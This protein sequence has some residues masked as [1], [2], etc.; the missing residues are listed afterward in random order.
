MKV[1]LDFHSSACVAS[2]IVWISGV[3][4]ACGCHFEPRP[5][6]LQFGGT[7]T[8]SIR[9]FPIHRKDEHPFS[10]LHIDIRKESWHLG[11]A[12]VTDLFAELVAAL[13]SEVVP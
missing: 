5:L 6:S 2:G 8:S 11:T 1:C 7:L 10:D 13:G 12:D 3:S 4:G 9:Q